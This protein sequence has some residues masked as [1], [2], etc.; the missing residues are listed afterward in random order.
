MYI[1]SSVKYLI[2]TLKSEWVTSLDLIDSYID[3]PMY[4]GLKVS[5]LQWRRQI[6]PVHCLFLQVYYGSKEGE[7]SGYSRTHRY[8]DDVLMSTSQTAMSREY[9]QVASSC[10][11]PGLDHKLQKN[12]I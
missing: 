4:L 3:I 5:L 7:T 1:P 6:L 10:R 8:I 2:F 11:K 12:Q 9:P